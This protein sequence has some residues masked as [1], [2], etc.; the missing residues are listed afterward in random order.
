MHVPG[1]R[2][3]LPRRATG[4]LALVLVAATIASTGGAARAADDRPVGGTPQLGQRLTSPATCAGG[5][6]WLRDGEPVSGAISN[7]YTVTVP[8]L[9]H[10]LSVRETCTD[11]SGPFTSAATVVVTNTEPELP[12]IAAVPR[13]PV[14]TPALSGPNAQAGTVGDPT[15]PG[16][17]LY[18]GQVAVGG[19]APVDPAQLQVTA[20]VSTKGTRISPFGVQPAAD[21]ATVTGTGAVRSVSFKPTDPGNAHVVVT[22]TGTT[23]ETASYT[24]DYYAS[25]ATTPTSRTLQMSSDASTAIAAGGGY[26]FVASDE[27]RPIRLYDGEVS[28][29]PVA[30]FS[31][32]VN[33]NDPP[34]STGEDD[35]ESSARTG[36]SVFWLGSHGN[37]KKGEVAT[38]RHVVYETTISGSGASATLTPAGRYG[39]LRRDL[40][41]WDRANGD[42]YGF[43]AATAA[44]QHPDG[45]NR[46]NIEAAEFAPD[47]TTLHLGFRSPLVGG[48]AGGDALIVPVTNL[49]AL[50]RGQAGTATFGEPIELDLDGQS[51]RE[52]RR[53]A[54]GEYLILSADAAF[55]ADPTVRHHPQQLWYWNGTAAMAPQR[56]TSEAPPNVEKC[57]SALG[58]W[59][60]IGELPASLDPG[61]EVRLI[62][63]QGYDCPYSAVLSGEL[64]NTAFYEVT[65]QKDLPAVPLRRG[66]TDVVTLAGALGFGVDVAELDA[67]ARQKQ[68]TSSAARPVT[69][70]NTGT[71]PLP[72]GAITVED[73]DSV[74]AAD[75]T[76]DG[77]ACAH[78]TL[79]V[80]AAC[81]LQ[82]AFAPARGNATSTAALTVANS[83]DGGVSTIPLTG[84]S[85]GVF[86]T[87]PAPVIDNARP[88]VGDRL[89]GS[90]AAWSPGAS[91][92]WEWLRD[93]APIA[94]ATAAS[95]TTTAA[96]T[97]TVISVRVSGT[98]DG[99]ESAQRTSTATEK[100]AAKIP[101]KVTQAAKAKVQVKALKGRKLQVSVRLSGTSL[102]PTVRNVK[103]RLTG[104]VRKSFIVTVKNGTATLRLGAAA[105]KAATKRVKVRVS[106]PASTVSS[107]TT[108]YTAKKTMKKA[109]VAV[110]K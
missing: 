2:S 87:S 40:V 8:D 85:T 20:A 17:D 22:V 24:I 101:S 60:G 97:D 31:P 83:A 33:P 3:A 1:T 49:Q 36:D 46:F 75:F 21:A 74:S 110:R 35:Y 57:T 39:N 68:G 34:G 67:F 91:F 53:N 29:L 38:S 98:A 104:A 41:A 55:S 23:G 25:R 10:R 48:V 19:Q 37:S 26:F 27:D 7:S 90:V 84:T 18:V 42:R 58:A 93:G 11:G 15:N 63:D 77:A 45:P 6:Q 94:G 72:I 99:Y 13:T 16:F 95:Y 108:V 88:Q 28:G 51:I 86:T 50:T 47:G 80:D 59:E 69:V 89:T 44:G 76:V 56:L 14:G 92:A 32:G 96:D 52:I 106:V 82:V 105:K 9:G 107:A 102:K 78:S 103:V 62:M 109:T 64:Y 12:G 73:E 66:R 43:A 65:Q 5:D 100:V 4:T 30:T 79:A 61:A 71:K 70:T 54:A 81:T